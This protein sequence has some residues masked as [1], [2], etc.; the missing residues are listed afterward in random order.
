MAKEKKLCRCRL[1]GKICTFAGKILQ[2]HLGSRHNMKWTVYKNLYLSGGHRR[3][4]NNARN[5]SSSLDVTGPVKMAPSVGVQP[6]STHEFSDNVAD[7][8]VLQCG[9]CR[10]SAGNMTEHVEQEHRMTFSQYSG[11]YADSAQESRIM[12]HRWDFFILTSNRKDSKFVVLQIRDILVRI[13]IRGSV[14][15]TN[16]SGSGR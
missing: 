12:Y 15:M 13:R 4:S 14:P 10:Q 3:Q 1:C 11:L 16:G 8:M 6:S 2:R 7:M 5:P 9:I